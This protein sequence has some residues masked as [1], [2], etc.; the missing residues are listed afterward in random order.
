MGGG[1]LL[2]AIDVLRE[3]TSV[4]NIERHG[5][6]D[7]MKLYPPWTVFQSI[8]VLAR[9]QMVWSLDGDV[10]GD[11]DG[12]DDAVPDT[13]IYSRGR[14]TSVQAGGGGRAPALSP[15]G[16]TEPPPAAAAEESWPHPNPPSSSSS[17]PPG[18]MTP[19]SD[20]L[21]FDLARYSSLYYRF[22]NY[23]KRRCIF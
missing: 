4:R 23:L 16:S 17:S 22:I 7:V 20:E 9:L 5:I 14:P 3:R 1:G 15:P 8:Y 13:D 10:D 18:R 19:L 12:D 21:I 2:S 6:V 11:D